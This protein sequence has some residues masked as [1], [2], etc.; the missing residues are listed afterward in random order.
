MAQVLLVHRYSYNIVRIV[1]DRNNLCQASAE[2]A[3]GSGRIH[4]KDAVYSTI[5]FLTIIVIHHT[6]FLWSHKYSI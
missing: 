3:G 1:G 4:R 5:Y 6:F 2:T